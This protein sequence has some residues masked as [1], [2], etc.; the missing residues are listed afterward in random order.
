MGVKWSVDIK[1]RALF[2]D[3]FKLNESG[4]WDLSSL[5]LGAVI[6]QLPP[7]IQAKLLDQFGRKHE[8]LNKRGVVINLMLVQI[9]APAR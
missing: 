3:L 9:D 2:Y 4:V 8:V 7:A 5:G 6:A 1:F